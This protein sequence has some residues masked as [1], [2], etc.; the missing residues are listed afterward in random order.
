MNIVK[1]SNAIK[2]YILTWDQKGKYRLS[3]FLKG[4]IIVLMLGYGSS[5]IVYAAQNDYYGTWVTTISENDA[6]V[7]IKY[8]ISA[9]SMSVE[10][11]AYYR[12]EEPEIMKE[13]GEII[14]WVETV[15]NNTTTKDN[16]PN[17]VIITTKY[18]GD[19]VE[20]LILYISIDKKQCV[21][22]SSMTEEPDLTQIFIKK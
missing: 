22:T 2:E 20:L 11:I 5:S 16:F 8:I 9:K 19:I 14:T 12:D 6:M 1:I 18:E 15:N 7:E 13:A 17:G 3:L 4:V 21:F 10:V